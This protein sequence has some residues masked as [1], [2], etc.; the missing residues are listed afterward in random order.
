MLSH[1][2]FRISLRLDLDGVPGVRS[3]SGIQAGKSVPCARSATARCFC[4]ACTPGSSALCCTSCAAALSE[5]CRYCCCQQF[6]RQRGEQCGRFG[7]MYVY[8]KSLSA[9]LFATLSNL[10]VCKVITYFN[11]TTEFSCEK[12]NYTSLLFIFLDEMLTRTTGP[13]SSSQTLQAEGQEQISHGAES[14]L[15]FVTVTSV[16]V[17]YCK[18]SASDLHLTVL[19]RH[20]L[21]QHSI[22]IFHQELVLKA[23]LN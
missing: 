16:S 14:L 9:C 6:C 17:T 2:Q 12:N 5:G 21:C 7:S 20:S 19:N 4:S 13:N 23:Q 1:G 3:L 11:L 18:V 22:N 15:I 10:N 8:D